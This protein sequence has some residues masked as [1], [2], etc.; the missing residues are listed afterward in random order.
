[1]TRG[2]TSGRVVAAQ[3][4]PAEVTVETGGAIFTLTRKAD[5]PAAEPNE[6]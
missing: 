5:D 3:F 1:M 2:T 4:A 6:D